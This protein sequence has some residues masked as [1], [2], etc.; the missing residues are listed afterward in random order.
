MESAIIIVCILF[1]SFL[2]NEM[3]KSKRILLLLTI[4][5]IIF[6]LA[7][8]VGVWNYSIDK[9]S[10]YVVYTTSTENKIINALYGMPLLPF[11]LIARCLYGLVSPLPTGIFEIAEMFSNYYSFRNV[12]VSIGIIGQIICLP[13]L[14]KRILRIDYMAISF[15]I[16]Y[17]S[18][19]LVT[20]GFRH[21]IL[22]Y[23]LMFMLI[24]EEMYSINPVKRKNILIFSFLGLCF[25]GIIFILLF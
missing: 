12:F 14:F 2:K 25:L 4:A 21:I 8:V 22:S 5:A 13:F 18:N 6:A 3:S 17:M 9:Y 11:G 10:R 15:L 7:Y 23:P 16:I 24:Y 1:A 20:S 19:R